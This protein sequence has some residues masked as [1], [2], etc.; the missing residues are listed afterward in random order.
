LQFVFHD[1]PFLLFQVTIKDAFFHTLNFVPANEEYEV[2]YV[3]GAIKL[4]FQQAS[5][6]ILHSA[7]IS[8]GHPAVLLGEVRPAALQQILQNQGVECEL[9]SGVLVCCNGLVNVRKVSPTQIAIDGALCEEYFRIREILYGQ[10]EI[11]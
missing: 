8:K 4:N 10:Y 6:P 7:T 5:F 9:V 1:L 11:V 3:Q 2:A